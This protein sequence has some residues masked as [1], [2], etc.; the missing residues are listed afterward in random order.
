MAVGG[1][2][3]I[4]RNDPCPCGSG[5]KYKKCCLLAA[6]S[7]ASPPAADDVAAEAGRVR[8]A[9]IGTLVRFAGRPE[10]D[11][12]RADAERVFSGG[13]DLAPGEAELDDDIGVKFAF[14]YM[15][16]FL[17]PGG[18]TIAQEF[19]ARPGPPLAARQ[20]R[21]V[22]R[23]SRAHLRLYEVEDVRV[24]E[25]LRLR[26]LRTSED[27]FVYER[28]GTHQLHRWD[29]LAVR[30]APDDEGALRLEGG[31]YVLPVASKAALLEAIEAEERQ[32]RA[33]DPG[34]DDETLWR[35]CAPLV[36]RFWLDRVVSRPMP[37]MLTAEGDAM[38]FGKVLFDVLDEP[39]VRSALGRHPDLVAEEDGSY[40]WTEEAPEF[41][42][43][44]GRIEIRA[45]GRLVLEVMSR[46]RAE[47]GRALLEQAAGAALRHRS[48]RF[49]SVA[50]ALERHRSAPSKP[51]EEVPP[52]VAAEVL[53]QYKDK[54]YKKWPDEPLP[55]LDGR[56]ARE[57]AGLPVLR[58]R[59]VDLLKDME[60]HETR[61][62]RP[63]NPPYDFG[64]IWKELGV[65][66]PR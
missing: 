10:F 41:R 40:G 57:A 8:D 26:D 64:W 54:H 50:K 35:R 42:R 16:D 60:N 66:R 13:S 9:A 24:D 48:T 65:E 59:L 27:L 55:A 29:V 63:G 51:P 4:G 53:R 5:R 7:P 58:P 36:H 21:L 17:L 32:L 28:A 61:G 20:Q 3:K 34:L 44:L 38:A 45:D 43:S 6:E 56:T 37:T 11:E 30:V 19:L 1:S 2:V 33:R 62:T 22:H 25:G 31:I 18:R 39:A 49:E 15:F 52:E 46:P 14:F 47:R 12:A 23:L